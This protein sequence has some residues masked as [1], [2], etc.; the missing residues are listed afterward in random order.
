MKIY[1][2]QYPKYSF[3]SQKQKAAVSYGKIKNI[4]N[5]YEIIHLCSTAKGSSGSPILNLDNNKVIG[6]HSKGYE[7]YNF[8]KGFSLKYSIKEYLNN[9]NLINIKKHNPQDNFRVYYQV[10]DK[11]HSFPEHMVFYYY[12]AKDKETNEKYVI[13]VLNKYLLTEE[14]EEDMKSYI[15]D[16][17][18]HIKTMKMIQEKNVENIVK[19]YEYFD[20]DKEF[21]IV[22]EFFDSSLYTY[23]KERK[24]NMNIKEIYDILMQLNNTFKVMSENK[25]YQD[26]ITLDNIVLKE[27]KNKKLIFKLLNNYYSREKLGTIIRRYQPTYVGPD[28]NYQYLPPEIIKGEKYDEISDLWSLGILIYFLFFKEFPNIIRKCKSLYDNLDNIKIYG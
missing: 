11:I 23:F 7:N 12:K 8:N 24:D 28:L 2:I 9:I 26:Y 10:I 3:N 17:M 20:N 18:D 16:L 13:K 21:A 22:M 5:R 14:K 19:C 4:Q 1:I 6:I 15:N 25:I 27:D